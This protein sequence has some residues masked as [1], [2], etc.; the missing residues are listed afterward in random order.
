MLIE[1]NAHSIFREDH[2]EPTTPAFTLSYITYKM[3][4]ADSLLTN[5]RNTARQW[6]KI[7]FEG[8]KLLEQQTP[9]V[10]IKNDMKVLDSC[11]MLLNILVWDIDHKPSNFAL[12]TLSDNVKRIQ[13]IALLAL[14]DNAV[15][16]KVLLS[17]PWNLSFSCTITQ[18]HA[19]YS[20]KGTGSTLMRQIY[21][22]ARREK[23][24]WITL[25]PLSDSLSFYTKRIGMTEN[26]RSLQL[27]VT[28]DRLPKSLLVP[29]GNLFE[30]NL[31][32][33]SNHFVAKL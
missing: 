33:I 2:G 10:T 9:S 11:H 7:V 25:L 20:V 12:M 21:E 1:N 30:K 6:L 15:F 13:G 31:S 8:F 32:G 5:V 18:K 26:N 16:V 14:Q 23:K 27:E 24:Q 17:A 19:A 29:S 22:L 28:K 4:D 3:Q